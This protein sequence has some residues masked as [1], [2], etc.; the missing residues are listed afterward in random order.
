M[1][2]SFD[3][4]IY[5]DNEYFNMLADLMPLS[6]IPTDNHREETQFQV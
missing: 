5:T 6:L 1:W 4:E 2:M 3:S